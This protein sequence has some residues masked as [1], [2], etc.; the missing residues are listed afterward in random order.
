MNDRRSQIDLGAPDAIQQRVSTLVG[1]RL[2]TRCGYNLVGQTI[3][4][5][6][7]YNL[8][9]VRCPECGT[10]ASVQEYP[11]LGR[12]AGRWAA[13]LAAVWLLVCLGMLFATAG[14][15][16][17]FSQEAA[18]DS[19]RTFAKHLAERQKTWMEGQNA[20]GTLNPAMSWVLSQP[21]GAYMAA[22]PNWSEQQDLKAILAELGGWMKVVDWRALEIWSRMGLTLLPFGC[23]WGVA[24]IQL[25]RWRLA[26]FLLAPLALVGIFAMIGW[27]FRSDP[28]M[29]PWSYYGM[30]ELARR[31]MGLPIE[32]LT[33]A[34]GAAVLLAGLMIG[35]PLTRLLIRALLPPRLR[36][37]LALLWI[38]DGLTPPLASAKAR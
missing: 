36:S 20:A 30:T 17:G 22:D 37:S 29:A 1:D 23:F 19:C 6:T 2:C 21:A 25:R 10:V 31:E 3:W 8:L 27:L 28:Q 16:Y 18:R 15:M 14:I 33:M 11:L 26:L 32:L 34:F 5:E 12:W 4:R 9:I 13:L 24:M 38:A 35:R 7:H